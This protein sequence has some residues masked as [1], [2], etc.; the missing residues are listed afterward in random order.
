M[1]FRIIRKT[2]NLRFKIND[3]AGSVKYTLNNPL[4]DFVPVSGT[5]SYLIKQC[6]PVILGW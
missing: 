5:G 4:I 3:L 6:F 2:A 1:G